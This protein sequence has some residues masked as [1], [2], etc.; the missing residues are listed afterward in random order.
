MVETVVMLK[1]REEWRP[2][3]GWDDLINEM[4]EALRYPGMPNIWWMPIQTRTEMLS[5]GIRSPL[6]IKIFGSDLQTIERTAIEIE[7]VVAALPGPDVLADGILATGVL[8]D[9]HRVD[10]SSIIQLQQFG[11]GRTCAGSV[12]DSGPAMIIVASIIVASTD[13]KLGAAQRIRSTWRDSLSLHQGIAAILR[14][15]RIEQPLLCARLHVDFAL[16][17]SASCR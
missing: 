9:R 7:K 16:V 17:S 12:S 11:D 5:T 1:P 13:R 2:G 15:M 4:D 10:G 6:G 8:L 3:L 14:L